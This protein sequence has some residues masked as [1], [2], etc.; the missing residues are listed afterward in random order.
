MPFEPQQATAGR[1]SE[2]KDQQS[3]GLQ[4]APLQFRHSHTT[5]LRPLFKLTPT[6]SPGAVR[7][8]V[9]M[10]IGRRCPR[11]QAPVETSSKI[12]EASDAAAPP[13]EACRYAC[14]ARDTSLRTSS[15]RRL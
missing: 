11:G 13:T 7:M 4:Y 2:L 9:A 5:Q 1:L 3:E 6:G 8:H 14:G 10:V 12:S 15:A